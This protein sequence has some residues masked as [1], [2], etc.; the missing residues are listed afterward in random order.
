E[1]EKKKY[2]QHYLPLSNLGKVYALQ[3]NNELATKYFDKSLIIN[4]KCTFCLLTLSQ[5]KMKENDI[6]LANTYVNRRMQI[7]PLYTKLRLQKIMILHNEGK[8]FAVEDA[9]DIAI[10][11]TPSDPK[12]YYWRGTFFKN[13]NRNISAIADFEKVISINPQ[14]IEAITDLIFLYNS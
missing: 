4:P 3:E 1:S 2:P 7:D 5:I 14:A 6:Q 12:L 9:L 13:Q 8:L 11:E 10:D